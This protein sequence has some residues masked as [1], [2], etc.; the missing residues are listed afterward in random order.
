[1]YIDYLLLA[2]IG[3]FVLLRYP[4]NNDKINQSINMN[5]LIYS[6]TELGLTP[7]YVVP[8]ETRAI[9]QNHIIDRQRLDIGEEIG[10]GKL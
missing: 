1:V 4:Y 3:S 10:R 2:A 5:C 6:N 8:A 9:L 7:H